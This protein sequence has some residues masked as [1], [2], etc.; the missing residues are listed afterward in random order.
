MCGVVGQFVRGDT[1]NRARLQAATDTLGH[2]GPDARHVHV[3]GPVGLGHT[4]LSIIDVAGGDQPLTDPGGLV[5][6]ANGEIYNHVELRAE[7]EAAGYRFATRSDCE[8][9]VH[10]WRRWGEDVLQRLHGMFAFALHDRASGDLVLARDRLGIKPLFLQA[11]GDGVA[12]ASEI[13]ALLALSGKTPEVSPDGL[14]QYFEHQCAT[15]RTTAFAGIER[16]LPGELAVIRQGAIARRRTY[17]TATAT[18]PR[19]ID[20]ATALEEFDDLVGGVMREHMRS[21]VPWGLFLSGGVD[22]SILLALLTRY[23]ERPIR[24]FSVG[25]AGTRITDELPLATELAERFGSEHTQ[26]RPSREDL[27]GVLPRTVWAA[28]ELMRDYANLPTAL[29]AEHAAEDVKVVFS[30][31]GG[32]E[33]FGGYGRYRAPWAERQLKALL[34]PG[35]GGFRT[36]GTFGRKGRGLFRPA[37]AQAARRAREPIREAWRAAR[38]DWTPFTRMQYVDLVTALPDNLLVKADRMLMAAS[39]EGRVPFLDHRVVEFGL[40]LPDALKADAH[41][42]KRFL[43]RWAERYVPAE[44]LYARKRGFHVP[45]A[46]WLDADYLARMRRVLP[47]S[48]GIE[49][50]CRP[51]AVR[52]L[53]E[54]F[55][56]NSRTNR[57]VWALLQFAVWHRMFI[58]DGGARPPRRSDPLDYLEGR[59]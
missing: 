27:L 7:L 19:H 55:G 25:F 15:G 1:A 8:V 6:V 28:D 39:V 32:D 13:K 10:G 5:L 26:I 34:A 29:L 57:M 37:L 35:S 51:A 50:W 12:F 11:D 24:T 36:R 30:G 21:D 41:G 54:S 49:S 20:E 59:Y 31:E 43:K 17:W 52:T 33:V 22:S 40:S 23:A 42:G 14:A 53:I 47:A 56:R 38:S 44:H 46:Q 16:L 58:E 9:I 18:G 48:A 3:D 45:L 2:R 4:R